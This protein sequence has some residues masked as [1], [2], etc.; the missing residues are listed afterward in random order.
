MSELN[1]KIQELISPVLE[2]KGCR[3]VLGKLS[4]NTLQ[5]LLE[6]IDNVPITIDECVEVGR[7][8]SPILDESNLCSNSCGIEVS[9]AGIDRP[10]VVLEDFEKFVG[11]KARVE[12]I[13]SV[14]KKKKITGVI[15]SV[16][17]A[18]IKFIVRKEEFDTDFYNIKSAKL[19]LTDE[20]IAFQ[21]SLI[22][23]SEL[24][25]ES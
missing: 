9:S 15:E 17:E 7:E 11:H 19:I 5:L 25:D 8:V 13:E 10:L 20:L 16:D 23:V 6:R 24:T 4:G 12:F 21:R 14:N 2:E 3:L 1:D 22:P 18:A